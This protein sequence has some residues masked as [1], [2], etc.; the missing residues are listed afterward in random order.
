MKKKYA[1]FQNCDSKVVATVEGTWEEVQ[2]EMKK[3]SG[4]SARKVKEQEPPKSSPVPIVEQSSNDTLYRAYTD[5]SYR[6]GTKIGWAGV[7]VKGSN[8]ITTLQGSLTNPELLP[9]R[10]IPGELKAA[11]EAVKWAKITGVKIVIHY[12]YEGVE[13]WVTGEWKAKNSIT[14]S[15]VEWMTQHRAIYSF[16]KVKAHSGDRWN[17]MA[18]SAAS[19]EAV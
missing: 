4:V 16:V 6:D 9:L 14:K 10:Q 5:G 19:G 12:D 11:M 1:I 15:Y 17:E 3:Y 2:Q 8:L 18:D 7:I 13:K